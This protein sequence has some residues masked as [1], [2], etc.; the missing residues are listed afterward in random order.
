MQVWRGYRYHL[1]HHGITSN[2]GHVIA[3]L[4]MP[5]K[6]GV[7]VLVL[8]LSAVFMP[9]MA[10]IAGSKVAIPYFQLN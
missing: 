8:T 7:L 5:T 10:L 1:I 6:D 3:S 4:T 9:K 2:F